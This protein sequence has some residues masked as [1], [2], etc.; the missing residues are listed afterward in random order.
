MNKQSNKFSL[1]KYLGTIVYYG[2]DNKTANKAVA[3]VVKINDQTVVDMKK[4]YSENG[5][6]FWN[7][8]SVFKEM[9]N[10][11]DSYNVDDYAIA[12]QIFGCPHET[13]IDYPEEKS[14]PNVL[15][16]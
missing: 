11:L 7:D 3:A 2:P 15:I 5:E 14:V 4:W 1:P 16:G 12:S 9:M 10:F 8:D 6:N 13:G